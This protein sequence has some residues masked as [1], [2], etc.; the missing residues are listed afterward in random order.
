MIRQTLVAMILTALFIS[1]EKET[2]DLLNQNKIEVSNLIDTTIIITDTF[3]YSFGYFG[4]EEGVLI[5]SQAQYSES[6]DLLNKQW[7]ERIL[8]YVP[9]NNFLGVDSV[10]V[11]S[12]RGSDG[13]S[14]ST[15]IDT[16][17]IIIKIVKNDFHK[18]LIGKWNW[19]S[20][21]GGI[22]GEC[23]YPS[24]DNKEEIEFDYN[25]DFIEKLNNSVVHEY[26]YGFIDSF[27]SGQDTLYKIGFDNGHDTYYRFVGDKLNIQGGDFWK[28]YEKIE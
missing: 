4:D 16:T 23:W 12:M 28:E 1:C 11:V 24:D 20:S 19:T 7:E 17:L 26:K 15:D 13:A 6:C 9:K 25:M 3:K 22:T 27:I 14:P 21:C 5:T 8:Q 10:T 2:D 18:K